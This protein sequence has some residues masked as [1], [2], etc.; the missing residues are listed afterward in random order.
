MPSYAFTSDEQFVLG[1]MEQKL[2]YESYKYNFFARFMKTVKYDRSKDPTD[3]PMPP[4]SP[5]VVKKEFATKG[6]HQMTVPMLRQLTGTE[7]YGDARLKGNTEGQPLNYTTVYINQRRNGVNPPSGMSDQYV[8]P[9]KLYNEARMQLAQK[10]GR[11]TEVQIVRAFYEK[12]SQNVTS[13]G[14]GGLSVTKVQHPAIF[15]ADAGQ[16]SWSATAATYASSIHSAVQALSANASEDKMSARALRLF[17]TACN[18]REIP[19]IEFGNGVAV[20]PLLMHENQYQQ[21]TLDSEYISAQE[22]ANVRHAM[23]NPLFHGAAGMFAGFLIFVREFSVFGVST[24]SSTTT[25]G[26]TN[27]LS[28]VDT[29]NYKGAICF[30]TN[31]ICG[32]WAVG[33]NFTTDDDDHENYREV[34]VR[35]IDGFA[36]ADY[37]DTL[38]EASVTNSIQKSSA[39]LITSSPDEWN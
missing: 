8:K 27:P 9:L 4:V 15:T 13:T 39:I 18:K 37:N 36:R 17:R 19:Y 28:A 16:V 35:I 7:K 23:K 33:P 32:G 22:N 26:A 1:L 20:R 3:Q 11:W 24:T 2:M 38:T 5:I 29:Y 12:F 6:N 10:L 34:G 21:L 30:S 14:E 25:W 31:A